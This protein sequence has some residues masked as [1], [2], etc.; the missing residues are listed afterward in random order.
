ASSRDKVLG[1]TVYFE[2]LKSILQD[3]NAKVLIF[4]ENTIGKEEFYR[5]WLGDETADRIIFSKGLSL[6]DNLC[7]IG[8]RHTRLVVGPCTGLMHCASSIYNNYVSNGMDPRDVPLIV[9]YT[10]QYSKANKSAHYWWEGAPLVNCLLLKAK[11]NRKEVVLL[12]SLPDAERE[13]N[14]TL[15]CRD[16]TAGLL[17]EFIHRKMSV[18]A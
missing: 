1:I 7:L 5:Q 14:D 15:P 13:L 11:N 8:S 9:V 3:G 6:R 4:D 10:G 17:T 2:F 12:S 18:S 16:Y